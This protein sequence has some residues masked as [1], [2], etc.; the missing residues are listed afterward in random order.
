MKKKIRQINEH[1]VLYRDDRTGVAWVTDGST[2]C[3]HSCHPN[4]D[5]TGSVKGMKWSGYWGKRDKVA[6]SNGYI[7]N[8][9]RLAYDEN[10]PLDMIA[11]EN[12]QCSE[13]LKR[14]EQQRGK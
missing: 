2:G 4:I 7:Y 1:S 5:I 14:K 13:C 3:S 8:I 9:T 11:L 12:C 10:D 6:R